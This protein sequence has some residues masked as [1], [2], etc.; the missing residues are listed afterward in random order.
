MND[1]I[2]NSNHNLEI[3]AH[4]QLDEHQNSEYPTK[5]NVRKIK[6]PLPLPTLNWSQRSLEPD[7]IFGWKPH[8]NRIIFKN[9]VNKH[10]KGVKAKIKKRNVNMNEF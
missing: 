5:T 9:D 8:R 1:K 3:V 4:S 2:I 6:F 10:A 7:M